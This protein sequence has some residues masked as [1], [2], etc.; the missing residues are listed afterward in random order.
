MR[1]ICA[2]VALHP[3]EVGGVCAPQVVQLRGQATL[4][5]HQARLELKAAK[6]EASQL[7]TEVDA[8]TQREKRTACLLR[9][10]V[11][12][13]S[14]SN[15]TVWEDS[16]LL[17]EIISLRCLCALVHDNNVDTNFLPGGH[18][19][20]DCLTSSGCSVSISADIQIILWFHL[21]RNGSWQDAEGEVQQE[22]LFSQ[23][24]RQDAQARC[25]A[26][27]CTVRDSEM[28]QR[29][30]AAREVKAVAE[31][32]RHLKALAVMEEGAQTAAAELT[33]AT[34]QAEADAAHHAHLLRISQAETEAARKESS[35]RQ[36]DCS[37]CAH[38]KPSTDCNF[39]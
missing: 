17:C 4:A 23:H 27:D 26:A 13:P 8:A 18:T 35:E 38:R 25:N 7:R 24:A 5:L 9:V 20:S 37:P 30:S 29:A 39:T 28:Q 36:V 32:E 10:G 33:T 21:H 15:P 11:F 31:A 2:C 12:V 1:L 14:A 34:Q 16:C 22:Q 6:H 19:M 3:H